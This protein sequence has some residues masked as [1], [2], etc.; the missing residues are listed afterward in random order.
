MSRSVLLQLARDSIQ[1]VLE[2]QNTIN[3]SELLQKHPLLS[4]PITTQVNI[5]LEKER[6]GYNKQ[7]QLPLIDA[8]IIAS[9]KAAFE[10]EDKFVL[11]TSKYLS[12]EIELILQTPEGVINE[13]DPPIL[14]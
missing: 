1:E 11:T 7:T 6:K 9:K 3:K 4:E 12:C 5:Y 13:I 2:A 8:I 10:N 14:K